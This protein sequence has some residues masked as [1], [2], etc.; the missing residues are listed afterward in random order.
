M[1]VRIT[2]ILEHW[3][4]QEPAL[5]SVLCLHEV[6]ANEQMKCAV[7]S[8]R[9]KLEY[10]PLFTDNMSDVAL[11]EAL[12]TEAVRILL[13]HPYARRP[14][15][16]SSQAIAVGSNLTVSDS[17]GYDRLRIE[18]PADYDL[19]KGMPYEWYSL[20]IQ[21]MLP[22][23][24]GSGNGEESSGDGEDSSGAGGNKT[25]GKES[26]NS[27][28]ENDG[29]K[30]KN[31][32]KNPKREEQKQEQLRQTAGSSRDLSELWEEDDVTLQL[33]NSAIEGCR[34]WGSLP[35]NLVERL[36]ASTRATI[37]WHNVFSGFRASVLSS[38]RKLTRMRPNRRM[39]FDAMGSTRRF[40]TRLL[41]AVDTSGS[42]SSRALSYFYGVINRAFR[43]GFE[44]IDVVQFD[45]GLTTVTT[46][47]RKMKEVA[48]VGRGGTSFQEP[49]DYAVE[50]GYDGL[51]MLT[52][53][54]A[55][56]PVLPDNCHTKLLWVCQDQTSYDECHSWME[57]LGRVC[58]INLS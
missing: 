51:V 41:V 28:S 52:D 25:S 40:D 32:G 22:E 37:N 45:C 27:A 18:I 43:Y 44:Q 14:D 19:A 53:G 6:E 35:G 2:R 55:P 20:R 7:R 31:K 21:E 54:Y 9:R 13:K 46:L 39:G 29:G 10:N 49:V 15:G 11:E 26:D 4:L 30:S 58:V 16:C 47:R 42:V 50:H 56:A 36:K 38:K 48:V 57:K 3:F 5:F 12:R 34:S 17:Y 1:D 24:G 23:I 8:G 33:I